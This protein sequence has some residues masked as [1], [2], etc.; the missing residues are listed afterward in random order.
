M[1]STRAVRSANSNEGSEDGWWRGRVI[2]R[3]KMEKRREN[4]NKEEM[5]RWMVMQMAREDSGKTGREN[6]NL[7]GT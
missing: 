5:A 2:E 6:R 7:A 3:A 1:C 4:G